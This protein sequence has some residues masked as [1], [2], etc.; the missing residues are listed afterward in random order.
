[1]LREIRSKTRLEGLQRYGVFED[2][3]VFEVGGN[4]AQP[5]ASDGDLVVVDPAPLV[6]VEEGDLAVVRTKAGFTIR[7]RPT[8][9]SFAFPGKTRFDKV[10]PLAMP[11]T[12]DTSRLRDVI[13]RVSHTVKLPKS[14][15][16]DEAKTLADKL[17]SEI[18][19][20]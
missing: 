3:L 1:M 14:P 6:V 5:F 12:W 18:G 11:W 15:R 8:L 10:D 13:G 19:A 20:E 2:Q 7:K 17:W 9:A 4:S 16:L